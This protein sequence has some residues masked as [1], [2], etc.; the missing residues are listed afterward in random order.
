MKTN[1]QFFQADYALLA[2]QGMGCPN[3][4]KCIEDS[5]LT[6]DGIYSVDVYLNMAVAEICFDSHKIS[7]QLLVERIPRG[8]RDGL[9]RFSVQLIVSEVHT[10]FRG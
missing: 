2:V 9:Y 1:G 7:A 6:Q 8:S 3:C 10:Y 4:A 5:L